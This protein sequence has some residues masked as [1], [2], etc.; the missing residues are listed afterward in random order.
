VAL[1]VLGGRLVIATSSGFFESDGTT[2]GTLPIALPG[3]P[4]RFSGLQPLQVGERL[5][6]PWSD[7]LHGPELWALEP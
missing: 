3:G 1:A 7:A 6:F 4:P 5:F 2:A